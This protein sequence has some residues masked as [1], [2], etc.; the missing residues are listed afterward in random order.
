MRKLRLQRVGRII[1]WRKGLPCKLARMCA[2]R[3][4]RRGASGRREPLHARRF[5]CEVG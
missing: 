1:L 2:P 4:K 3:L 5:L